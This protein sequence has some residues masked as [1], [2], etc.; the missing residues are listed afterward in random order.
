M[1]PTLARETPGLGTPFPLCHLLLGLT[2]DTSQA[3]GYGN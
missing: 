1:E 3:S 2:R